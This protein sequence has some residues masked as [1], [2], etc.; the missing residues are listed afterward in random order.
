MPKLSAK[1]R[2]LDA[3]EWAAMECAGKVRRRCGLI[4]N[5]PILA[6]V[7]RA[8]C[9]SQVGRAYAKLTV[10]TAANAVFIGK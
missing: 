2:Q 10:V 6:Q 1:Y 8:L 9:A 4:V 7:Q 5:S 3:Q